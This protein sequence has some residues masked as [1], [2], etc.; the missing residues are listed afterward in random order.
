MTRAAD[1][2]ELSRQ[3]HRAYLDACRID[4]DGLKPGNVSVYAPGHG[5]TAGQFIDSAAASGDALCA[6]GP[7]LGERIYRAVAATREVVGCNTN[8]GIILLAAPLMQAVLA[9]RRGDGLRDALVRVL[10]RTSHADAEWLY[11]AIRLAA[12][13][14]L[15]SAPA[16]DVG[17]TPSVTLTEAMSLAARRDRIAFQYA[18]AYTDIF[19]FGCGCY[20][21]FRR[22]W[23]DDVWAAVAVFVALAA[24][25]RDTHI[26]RKFGRREAERIREVFARLEPRVAQAHR[27]QSLIRDLTRLDRR[28]KAQRI[29]PGTTADLTAASVL[30]AR[31]DRF[32]SVRESPPATRH[33][34][35]SSGYQSTLRFFS[36]SL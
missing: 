2:G 5:M 25:F 22:R 8:L 34:L 31:L 33:D 4:V 28:L 32:F 10:G 7:E 18:N 27:P 3:L 36:N 12:P 35:R 26:E 21:D 15:G 17:G 30:C 23:H 9:G 16:E 11:Q 29:N 19:D 14:G 24:R 1:T 6:E 13:G 20:A